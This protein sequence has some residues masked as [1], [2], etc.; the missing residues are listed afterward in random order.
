MNT[1]DI[2]L[3]V[4]LLYGLYTGYSKGIFRQLAGIFGLVLAVFFSMKYAYLVKDF[5]VN[6]ELSTGQYAPVFSFVVA[7]LL[8]III[9]RLL[10]NLLQKIS[11]KLGLGIVER[12]LGAALG[13]LKVFLMVSAF[14]FFFVKINTQLNIVPQ[15]T[16]EQSLIYP[17]YE[18]GYSYL[19][20]FW[21]RYIPQ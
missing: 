18:M 20:Y 10:G 4:P 2:I 7:F 19:Q 16:F 5:L 9:V 1:I 11:H 6:N 15:K 8:V 14:L 21:T 13:V 17:Y 3:L 12:L